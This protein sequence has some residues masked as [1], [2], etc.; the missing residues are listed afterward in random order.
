MNYLQDRLLW[1]V[2]YAGPIF[3]SDALIIGG[4]SVFLASIKGEEKLGLGS[5]SCFCL[6][7]SSDYYALRT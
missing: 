3:C 4:L 5:Y 7:S 2:G 1:N 6:F